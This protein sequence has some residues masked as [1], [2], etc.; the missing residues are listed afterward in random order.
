MRSLK[1]DISASGRIRTRK[2]KVKKQEELCS[3]MDE[4]KDKA[5][6]EDLSL[7]QKLG[8]VPAPPSKLTREE[9]MSVAE[10]SRQGA[11]LFSSELK[12][13]LHRGRQDS[14]NDCA[15]CRESFRA[16]SQV[17]QAR[18]GSLIG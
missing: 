3:L 14:C 15:I 4:K 5:D 10:R 7:A 1:V 6:K 11:L 9:W 18:G 13:L 16:D 12:L 8:L 17:H 2:P